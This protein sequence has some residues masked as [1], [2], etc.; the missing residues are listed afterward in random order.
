MDLEARK[1][2]KQII[3][4]V[5]AFGV[6]VPFLVYMQFI[7]PNIGKSSKQTTTPAAQEATPGLAK[8][9]QSTSTA[10]QPGPT[11]STPGGGKSLAATASSPSSQSADLKPELPSRDDP[12]G[13]GAGVSLAGA[14]A[15]AGK[16][17][18]APSVL[19][20]GNW[21]V[22]DREATPEGATAASTGLTAGGRGV[23]APRLTEVR[24]PPLN[25][26]ERPLL[27][28]PGISPTFAYKY[29]TLPSS[30]EQ[31][32]AGA[33]GIPGAT[34]PLM[35]GMRL[36]GIVRAGRPRAILEWR[37]P[38]GTVASQVVSPN[39]PLNWRE[40][41]SLERLGSDYAI[42]KDAQGKTWRVPL[43]W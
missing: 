15:A 29:A 34:S 23:R 27:P 12:F 9:A 26:A 35:E 5:L 41:S 3:I 8:A 2:K 33:Q 22:A 43:R 32:A 36:S 25:V 7:R 37:T 13:L 17:A 31:I 11:P 4:I 30:A 19:S 18:P 24:I 10:P 16:A 28:V 42:I 20:S 14:G 38:K 21:G 1:R 6:A 39:E 40:G